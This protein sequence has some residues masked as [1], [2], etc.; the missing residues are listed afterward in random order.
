M[1]AV[2]VDVHKRQGSLAMQFEDRE[3]ASFA[4]FENR[5]EEWLGPLAALPEAW[6]PPR[7]I[8][9]LRFRVRWQSVY[10]QGSWLLSKLVFV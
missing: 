10:S 6:F 3:L 9:E 7:D 2:G 5:R 1:I 8:R 4:P